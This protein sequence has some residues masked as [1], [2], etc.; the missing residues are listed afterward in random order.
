MIFLKKTQVD[1]LLKDIKDIKEQLVTL[2]KN[3]PKDD[4][5]FITDYKCIFKEIKEK[6]NILDVNITEPCNF[7]NILKDILKDIKE[8]LEHLSNKGFNHQC[9]FDTSKLNISVLLPDEKLIAMSNN[10]ALM[11]IDKIKSQVN[12]DQITNTLSTKVDTLTDKINTLASTV[13]SFH[14]QNE[15]V[16]K[17]LTI[18]EDLRNCYQEIDSIKYT[19][20][21]KVND[22][23]L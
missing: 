8:K 21:P 7:D 23:T 12:L 4:S 9:N 14:F 6:L 11:I 16:K 18:E 13:D 17:Q 2:K 15:L 1:I 10:M 20:L 3:S 22:T 5:D 19:L